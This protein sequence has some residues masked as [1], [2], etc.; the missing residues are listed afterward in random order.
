MS[1]TPPTPG[2]GPGPG[3]EPESLDDRLDRLVAEYSDAVARGDAPRITDYLARVE[4]RARPGLER[5]LKMIDTGLSRAPAGLQPLV[6]GL[7]LGRY[8]LLREL[9]R[10]GMALVWLARDEELRRTVALKL[11]RPGLAFE[12][13][14]VDRFRREALAVA[15]LKHAHVVQIHDVGETGGYPYLAM[16]YVEGPSLATVVA[17]LPDRPHWSSDALAQAAGVPALASPELSFE[18][19][20]CKLL[21]PVADALAAAHRHGLVHRDVKPS[22][23]LIHRDG[24]AV[25]ADFG[26]AKAEGDP[27]LSLTGDTLGTPHYMSPE[28]A[29]SASTEVDHRT[30]VYS[31]G[32]T[33][34]E[35]LGGRRPFRGESLPEVFEAIKTQV[36]PP[37]RSLSSRVSRDADAVTARAMARR[38]QDRYATADELQADLERIVAGQRT[39]AVRKNRGL[40]GWR[41]QRRSWPKGTPYEYVSSR[42]FLGLPLVHVCSGRRLPGQPVRVAKGWFAVGDVA[43]G[44]IAVGGVS[45]GLVAMGGLSAGLLFCWGGVAAGLGLSFGG[46]SIG[47]VALGGVALGGLAFGG[48]ALGYGAVGGLAIGR[49]AAGGAPYGTHVLSEAAKDPEA[50]RFFSELWPSILDA[51]GGSPFG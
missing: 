28:Q 26:L 38:P 13:R 51:L 8:T 36:P 45:L 11:L 14:H 19:A 27:A 39:E 10:G 23:I 37:L 1:T 32:V 9:G 5:C 12:G 22:N 6:P 40:S 7:R 4:A 2:H 20:V 21:A 16:E 34:Y 24:R 33:L 17:A 50:Q 42:R 35:V 44:G 41:H 49:Y 18:Q 25:I 47:T 48:L 30:D 29:W 46:L 3:P 31:L 43:L 15:K